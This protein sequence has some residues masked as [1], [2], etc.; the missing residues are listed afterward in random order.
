MIPVGPHEILDLAEIGWRRK[1]DAA[2]DRVVAECLAELLVEL[3][4]APAKCRIEQQWTIGVLAAILVGDGNARYRRQ[5]TRHAHGHGPGRGSDT[6]SVVFGIRRS[7]TEL[8]ARTGS[9]GSSRPGTHWICSK[10]AQ[11]AGRTDSRHAL[12]LC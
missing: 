2:D 11:C 6:A 8:L 4:P 7:R 12:R 9:I 3:S 1:V 10:I 5:V